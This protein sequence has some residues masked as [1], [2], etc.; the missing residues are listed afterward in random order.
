[1]LGVKPFFS[2]QQ[3]PR[4]AR[5]L[6]GQC[7]RRNVVISPHGNT[8]DPAARISP[9]LLPVKHRASTMNEQRSQVSVTTLA[10]F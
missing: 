9:A 10:D 2:R 4:Y 8:L 6:I 5:I 3:C 7:H 1:M